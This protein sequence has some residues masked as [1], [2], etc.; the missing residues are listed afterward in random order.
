MER[1]ILNFNETAYNA[2]CEKIRE[3][4]A[5]LNGEIIDL[6]NEFEINFS[7][8]QLNNLFIYKKNIEKFCDS[9]YPEIRPLKFRTEA[10]NEVLK[11]ISRIASNDFIYKNG[12]NSADFFTV[13]K[14]IIT[15]REESF[16]TIKS[17]FEVSLETER[18]KEAYDLHNT[19]FEAVNAI[20]KMAK[21]N[22]G[23]LHI[24]NLF[25]YDRDFNLRKTELL[26]NMI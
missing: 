16:E 9:L 24:T 15:V 19:A 7:D 2:E 4:A 20:I 17:K 8:A 11:A 13:Q 10:R 21:E 5:Q 1:I 25:N 6:K 26:Y 12:F 22:G 18:A 23:T 3:A 14:G